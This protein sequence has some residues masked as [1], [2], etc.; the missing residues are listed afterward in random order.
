MG[1]AGTAPARKGEGAA[2]DPAELATFLAARGLRPPLSLLPPGQRSAVLPSMDIRA[3]TAALSKRKAELVGAAAL[4]VRMDTL[5]AE[6]S[7]SPTPTPSSSK[8]QQAAAGHGRGFDGTY[9]D[10]FVHHPH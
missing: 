7:G 2:L 10:A 5:R 1:A 4:R 6:S 8:A 3:S 9:Y